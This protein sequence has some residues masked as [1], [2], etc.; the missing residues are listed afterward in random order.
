MRFCVFECSQFILR[1]YLFGLLAFF[2]LFDFN[3]LFLFAGVIV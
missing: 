1:I 3:W 2:A